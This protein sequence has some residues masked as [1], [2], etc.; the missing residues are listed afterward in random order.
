VE[1]RRIAVRSQSRQIVPRD[2]IWKKLITKIGLEEW[3]KLEV[4]SSSPVLQKK[5]KEKSRHTQ[6][7]GRIKPSR[8]VKVFLRHPTGPSDI[9]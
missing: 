2:P 8:L 9:T 4:L 1:I 6:G 5:K 7:Q 3:L